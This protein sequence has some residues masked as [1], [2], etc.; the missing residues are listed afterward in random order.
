MYFIIIAAVL[1]AFGGP[2][3]NHYC[4]LIASQLVPNANSYHMPTRTRYQLVPGHFVPGQ[5]VLSQ[6]VPGQL[7]LS[8]FVLSQL[9]L[10]QSHQR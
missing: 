1:I 7:V 2:R 5:L 6:H 4:R 8:Q 3:L 10:S 9:V